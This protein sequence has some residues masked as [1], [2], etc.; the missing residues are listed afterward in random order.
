M[1]IATI[2]AATVSGVAAVAC[3]APAL[4]PALSEQ[5]RPAAESPRGDARS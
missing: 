5:S 2:T 3:Y 4:L 1:R